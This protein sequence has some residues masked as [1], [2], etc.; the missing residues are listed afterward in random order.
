M[1]R[2]LMG[3]GHPSSDGIVFE[4][5]RCANHCLIAG[6]SSYVPKPHGSVARSVT[7]FQPVPPNHHVLHHGRSTENRSHMGEPV[8]GSGRR[9]SLGNHTTPGSSM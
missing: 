6:L 1:Q 3:T 2:E 4:M 8:P 7:F 9:M 5:F